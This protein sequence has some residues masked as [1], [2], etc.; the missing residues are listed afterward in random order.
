MSAVERQFQDPWRQVLALWGDKLSDFSL[1]GEASQFFFI[2]NM[3][4]AATPRD[5]RYVYERQKGT[6]QFIPCPGSLR[7]G[8]P[9]MV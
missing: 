7:A 2:I 6:H 4:S 9:R 5:K 1:S 8:R 3:F